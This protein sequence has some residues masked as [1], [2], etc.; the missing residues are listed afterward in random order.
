MVNRKVPKYL[1]N[2]R[3]GGNTGKLIGTALGAGIGTAIAPGVGTTTGISIGSSVGSLADT[4]LA[5]REERPEFEFEDP[6]YQDRL[7]YKGSLS[8]GN[9]TMYY[10]KGGSLRDYERGGK[11]TKAPAMG[12]S[13]EVEGEEVVEGGNPLITGGKGEM[14][15]EGAGMFSINGPQH[16][17]G[18]VEATGGERVFSDKLKIP[19]TKKTY[20]EAAKEIGRNS[21]QKSMEK[22][23]N[24]KPYDPILKKS[25]SRVNKRNEAQ[26]DALFNIQEASKEAETDNQEMAQGGETPGI[27]YNSKPSITGFKPEGSKYRPELNDNLVYD[28][29]T[30]RWLNKDILDAVQR[31]RS[32]QREDMKDLAKQHGMAL[33]QFMEKYP[34]K[35]DFQ[36]EQELEDALDPSGTKMKEGGWIQKAVK[37]MEKSGTKGSLTR[38]AKNAGYDSAMK[39]ARHIMSNKDN[40]SDKMVQKANFAINAN[41][42]YGGKLPE[43]K[44]GGRTIKYAGGGDLPKYQDGNDLGTVGG[45]ARNGYYDY[46]QQFDNP[47]D[48]AV[49]EGTATPT[50]GPSGGRP[51]TTGP[52]ATPFSQYLTD[53]LM[54]QSGESEAVTGAARVAQT[55]PALYDMARSRDRDYTEPIYNPRRNE[56]IRELENMPTEFNIEPQLQTTRDAFRESVDA[57]GRYSASPQVTRAN[58]A[59]SM[60]QRIRQENKLQAQ[61]ENRENELE[62]NKRRSLSQQRYNVGQ[63]EA[64]S[65]MRNRRLNQRTESRAESMMGRGLSS[66]SATASKAALDKQN[67][68]RDTERRALTSQ[69]VGDRGVQS[70]MTSDPGYLEAVRNAD[71]ELYSKLIQNQTLTTD[72]QRRLQNIIG[73]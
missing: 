38:A 71:Q 63:S 21:G 16:E 34:T 25:L 44:G 31:K 5:D 53:Q 32:G 39:Y 52:S 55:I 70:R 35:E 20:A 49:S 42:R 45:A 65:I 61:K 57:V 60:G 19:G 43:Y 56:S 6:A 8:K 46:Q 15:E 1:K 3:K 18:G 40:F 29:T 62:A 27:N 41:K 50:E 23:L 47:Y 68:L 17:E 73:E 58:I 10:R 37:G 14:S 26:K 33:P 69:L 72:E 28:N 59:R 48:M 13:Y 11:V 67:R 12:S 54:E 4:A 24:K 51:A 36:K 22:K 9:S 30:G 2:Y 66:L 64:Q 7:N